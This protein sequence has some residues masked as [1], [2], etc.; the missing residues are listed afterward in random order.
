MALHL[1]RIPEPFKDRARVV[2]ASIVSELA[3]VF[4][5]GR[6]RREAVNHSLSP[7]KR[8]HVSR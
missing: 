4:G 3:R 6:Q 1:F 8:A 5:F 7:L 2:L